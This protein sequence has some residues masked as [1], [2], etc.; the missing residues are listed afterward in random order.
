ML[1]SRGSN[2]CSTSEACSMGLDMVEKGANVKPK[3]LSLNLNSCPPVSP[4][5]NPNSEAAAYEFGPFGTTG[6]PSHDQCLVN[7]NRIE[8]RSP[9][10]HNSD[11]ALARK[12]VCRSNSNTS[13]AGV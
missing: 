13:T 11:E 8:K 10:H 3:A 9:E 2:S 7:S 5:S 1:N 4:Y 6:T 12:R